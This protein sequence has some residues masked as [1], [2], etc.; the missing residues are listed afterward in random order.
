LELVVPWNDSQP[1][2]ELSGGVQTGTD[3]VM[4]TGLL[5][6]GRSADVWIFWGTNDAGIV[7]TSLWDHVDAVGSVYESTS[8]D[9]VVNG[10]AVDTAYNFRLYVTNAAGTAWTD[11]AVVTVE[12]N[13]IPVVNAGA[14]RTVAISTNLSWTPA[15]LSPAAWYD[16]ADANTITASGGAVSE[17]RD[18]SGNNFHVS[19]TDPAKQPAT[20]TRYINAENVLN[21]DGTTDTLQRAYESGLNPSSLSVLTVAVCDTPTDGAYH[22]PLTSRST[23]DGIITGYI[24]Y[25]TSWNTF[26]GYYGYTA[27]YR[28]LNGP[29]ATTAPYIQALT[30]DNGGGAYY[31]NGSLQAEDTTDGY[32]PVPGVTP[33]FIGAGKDDGSDYYWDGAIAEVIVLD[34]VL[35]LSERQKLEGYLAHKWG[36]AANLPAGHPYISAALVEAG[37]SVVLD[38]ASVTDADGDTLSNTW[39]VVSAPSGGTAVFDN[40]NLVSATVTLDTAGEYVL[41][42]TSDDGIVTAFDEVRIIVTDTNNSATVNGTPYAWLDSHGITN[43]YELADLDDPD[44]DGALTWEEYLAGTDPTNGASVFQIMTARIGID[45]DFELVWYG[46]TNSG[47]TTEFV[48]YRCTNLISGAWEPVS[49]NTRSATGTNTWNGSGSLGAA[50]FR[51]GM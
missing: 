49:T 24:F 21:F 36:L 43:D 22:S 46:T 4:L 33:F 38:D 11:V 23:V 35:T 17:W 34:S 6:T 39:T 26:A 31:F 42:L 13:G 50:F 25:K 40:T 18:K 7:S 2:V 32:V 30:A 5:S 1:F 28:T 51:I 10:L 47:V 9:A 27:G 14:D 8:F 19:Q 41:R 29:T 20:G 15:D 44:G 3:Q 12:A 45:G 48:V 37:A 16:A